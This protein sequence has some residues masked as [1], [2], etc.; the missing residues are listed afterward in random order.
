MNSEHDPKTGKQ[1][2]KPDDQEGKP[3]GS[4]GDQGFNRERRHQPSKQDPNGE[5]GRNPKDFGPA[6]D[7]KSETPD[8]QDWESPELRQ[9]ECDSGSQKPSV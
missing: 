1:V 6:P 5:E 8:R 3:Q 2:G 9:D 4:R 7:R